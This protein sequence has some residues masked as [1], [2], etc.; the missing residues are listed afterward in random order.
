LEGELELL[1]E[2]PEVAAAEAAPEAV[3]MSATARMMN[4]VVMT[5]HHSDRCH[6]HFYSPCGARSNGGICLF[7][8]DLNVAG[9]IEFNHSIMA[10]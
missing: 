10:S 8:R 9:E 3:T 5:L 2:P 1:D 6:Q 4:L 7:L